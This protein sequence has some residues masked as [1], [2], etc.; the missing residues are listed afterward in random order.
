MGGR[1]WR[2]SRNPGSAP[3]DVALPGLPFGPAPAT[4]RLKAEL[5][6]AIID[7]CLGIPCYLCQNPPAA[8]CHQVEPRA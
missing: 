1:G 6:Q 5:Q 2:C 3:R 4:H 7:I 8:A